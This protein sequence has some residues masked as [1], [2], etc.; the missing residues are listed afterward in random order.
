MDDDGW[1]D[2]GHELDSP[3]LGGRARVVDG[4]AAGSAYILL[5]VLDGPLAGTRLWVDDS[6]T[7]AADVNSDG[8]VLNASPAR[9]L[10]PGDDDWGG[11]YLPALDGLRVD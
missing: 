10:G 3:L 2:V 1:M 9:V 7:Y 4:L 11:A 5:E 6:L 8:F